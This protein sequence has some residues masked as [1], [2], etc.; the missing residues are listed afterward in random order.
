MSHD[1][2]VSMTGPESGSLFLNRC[3]GLD[4]QS[5]YS[6]SFRSVGRYCLVFPWSGVLF[7]ELIVNKLV[8]KFL[9]LHVT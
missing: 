2:L 6:Y 5:T 1:S 4:V 7:E 3:I 8:E 9:T